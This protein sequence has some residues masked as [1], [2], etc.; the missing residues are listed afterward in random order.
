MV[1]KVR[2]RIP[3]SRVLQPA[4]LMVN[5]KEIAR[6][7][8]HILVVDSEPNVASNIA[9]NLE[10][11][12][13]I[14]TGTSR[15]YLG[16]CLFDVMKNGAMQYSLVVTNEFD[17]GIGL[18]DRVKK[19]TPNTK[20]LLCASSPKEEQGLADDILRRPF[21]AK[22]LVSKADLLLGI[23]PPPQI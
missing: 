5:A 10:N 14:V 13:Y 3:G 1:Q 19:S 4:G 20:V 21:E 16:T 15:H 22:A 8:F 12:G 9:Y 23:T 2:P 18:I 7:R 6:S 11:A 17:G